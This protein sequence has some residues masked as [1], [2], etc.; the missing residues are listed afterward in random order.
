MLGRGLAPVAI[1]FKLD[2]AG[3]EL[4]VFGAPIVNALAFLALELDKPVL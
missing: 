1:L 2:F 4:F 3:Y